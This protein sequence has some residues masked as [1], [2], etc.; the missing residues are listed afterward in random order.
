MANGN[1]SYAFNGNMINDSRRALNFSY[2]VLNLLNG[3]EMTGGC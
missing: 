2:N 1:Y 3:V